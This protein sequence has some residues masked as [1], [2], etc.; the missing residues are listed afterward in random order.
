MGMSQKTISQIVNGVA[1]I[2]YRTAYKLEMVLGIP[3][4]FW[5][6]RE[7]RYRHPDPL[8][9]QAALDDYRAR[10]EQT[11]EEILKES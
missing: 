8:T 2:S 7:A 1:P 6:A 10:Q 5:N 9:V 11:G 3:A 4:R